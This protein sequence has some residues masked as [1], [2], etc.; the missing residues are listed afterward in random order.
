MNGEG[1][2]NIQ[3]DNSFKLSGGISFYPIQR[4]ILRFYADAI[5]KDQTISATLSSFAGYNYESIT[6][7]A[8]YNRKI[9]RDFRQEHH[10]NGVSCYLSYDIREK[11]EIFGRYDWLSSNIPAEYSQPWNLIEDGSAIIF[12]IQYMPIRHIK[13]ALNYQDWVPYASNISNKRYIFLNLEVVL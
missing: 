4:L 7:G 9:N 13:L 1:Y 2:T 8:E 6:A 10:Q 12:G 5:E 3:T 11:Y